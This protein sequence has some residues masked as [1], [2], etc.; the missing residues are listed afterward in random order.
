MLTKSLMLFDYAC[1]QLAYAVAGSIDHRRGNKFW[2]DNEQ[3]TIF[4]DLYNMRADIVSGPVTMK[5]TLKRPGT[6]CSNRDHG[7]LCRMSAQEA[8]RQGSRGK[9]VGKNRGKR[10]YRGEILIIWPTY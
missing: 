5:I 3:V 8:Q 4:L 1:Q 2:G 6:G 9:S 10:V 7:T